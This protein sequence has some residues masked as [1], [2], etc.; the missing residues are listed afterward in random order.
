MRCHLLGFAH[1]P[2][3]PAHATHAAGGLVVRM[4]RMLGDHGHEAVLYAAEGSVA[5]CP[6][7]TVLT[8][9]ERQASYPPLPPGRPYEYDL[10]RPAHDLFRARATAALRER[11]EPGDLLLCFL[12]VDQRPVADACGLPALEPAIGNDQPSLAW[13][14]YASESCRHV[15]HARERQ[16]QG[17]PD[18][19]MWTDFVIPHYFD[20]AEHPFGEDPGESFLYCGRVTARKGVALAVEATRRLG[21]PLLVAGPE[22]GSVDLSAPH[23][24][25]LGEVSAAVRSV[26]M[27]RAAATFAPTLY[28]EPFGCSAVE[29]MF[30]GTPALTTDWGAY[31]ETVEEG[32]TGFRCRSAEEFTEAA[33]ACLEGRIDR[34]ACWARAMVRFSM[35][36]LW[37]RYER[38][39]RARQEAYAQPHPPGQGATYGGPLWG[40]PGREQ[41]APLGQT[42]SD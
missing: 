3:H 38:V 19:E 13:R 5:P 40:F 41:V 39:L 2:V 22:D 32:V 30:A 25:Y 37:P 16:G 28:V 31:T 10:R 34:R 23:V 15:C 26:L 42:L 27:A 6:V 12:G 36:S 4:A 18:G 17:L 20:P 24:R 14:V 8:E 21:K 33:R 1:L 9:G 29:G 11:A 35:T 7:V